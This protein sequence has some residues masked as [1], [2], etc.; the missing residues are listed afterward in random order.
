[1]AS[2]LQVG[3]GFGPGLRQQ[4]DP[5]PEAAPEQQPPQPVNAVADAADGPYRPAPGVAAP[6]SRRLGR[7][8]QVAWSNP[9]VMGVF[10]PGP[11]GQGQQRCHRQHQPVAGDA[12][13]VGAPGLVPLPAQAFDGL[14]AQFDPEAPGVPTGS[15]VLQRQVG[16]DDPR[17][18]LLD[19]PDL[20]Q[21][22]AAFCVGGAE[23]GAAANPGRTGTGN[24]VLCGQPAAVLGAEADV[25]PIPHVGMPAL[26][27][28][29]S[30]Q[31][32]TGYAPVAEHDDGHFLGHRWG[33]FPVFADR[34]RAAL[35]RGAL[36]VY[37]G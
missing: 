3:L 22:A 26:G 36:G 37:K 25:L 27:A 35:G 30:P 12:R 1:M 23:G 20:Q 8:A 9:A 19:V 13:R 31:L 2:N 10:H 33:Q 11:I 34:G 14:E 6:G 29:L 32:R 5:A 7:R 15:G 18:F 17:F 21:G 4:P 28:Y 16:E 24:E